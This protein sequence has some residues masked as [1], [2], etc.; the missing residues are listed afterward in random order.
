MVRGVACEILPDQ[1][2]GDDDFKVFL[3]ASGDKSGIPEELAGFV[4]Y[5]CGEFAKDMFPKRLDDLLRQARD[6]KQWEV[7]Y[8]TLEMQYREKI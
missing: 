5:L 4:N 7:E 2:M 3:N 8:M 6:H 1:A